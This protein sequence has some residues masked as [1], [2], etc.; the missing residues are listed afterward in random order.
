MFYTKGV[1]RGNHFDYLPGFAESFDGI[2]WV[3]KDHEIGITPSP[4]GWD[5]EMLC[6]PSLIQYEDKIY[7]FYN[8]NGM[9]KSGFGYAILESW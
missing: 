4:R 1:K 5:S 3:R 2:H 6:Y 7:M 8:G 9:G